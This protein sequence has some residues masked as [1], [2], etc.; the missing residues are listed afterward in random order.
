MISEL[1]Q[2]VPASQMEDLYNKA[3]NSEFKSKKIIKGATHNDAWIKGKD[4][5][6]QQIINFLSKCQENK[7][8]ILNEEFIPLNQNEK[9]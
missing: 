7:S 9:L 4:D 8:K 2:L 1:D 3:V 6:F 5:Y